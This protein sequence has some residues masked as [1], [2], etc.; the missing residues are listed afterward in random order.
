MFDREPSGDLSRVRVERRRGSRSR[1]T[2]ACSRPMTPAWSASARPAPRASATSAAASARP[3]WRRPA[4][5]RCSGTSTRPRATRRRFNNLYTSIPFVLS[6]QRRARARA[7]PR[8]PGPRRVRPRARR[9]RSAS[10]RPPRGALVYYVFAGPTPRDVL[11]QYTR[12][13]RPD[14]AAA[15][16]GAR[17]PAVQVGLQ[18]ADEVRAIARG[19][20]ERGIPCDVR[21]PRHRPH[22]RLP[23]LHVRRRALPGPGGVRR[24]AR[25][26]RLQGRLH[27]RPGREG[28]RG[29]RRLRRRPRARPVLQDRARRPST[30]TSSGPACA[31]SRTSRTRRRASGGATSRR[32]CVDAGVAG[33][34]CDMDEPALFVP[35]QSTMPERRR[36]PGRRRAR[37][38]T[39]RSTTSTAR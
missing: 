29:L 16:V 3:G 35:D 27:H 36:P 28:R 12:A 33:V 26:R 21:L 32:R 18:D 7:L 11:A 23:R 37:G 6:L 34:W 20:R 10:R 2:V 17:Q 30:A 39:S 15:A 8:Q 4:R 25:G 38:C 22:G 5:T 24:R 14:L 1:P 13:D 31:R 19:Y 9:T